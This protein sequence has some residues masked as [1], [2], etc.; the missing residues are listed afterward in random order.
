MSSRFYK[1]LPSD[2][3]C[4]DFQYQEGLNTIALKDC[5]RGFSFADER[6]I[7]YFCDMGSVIA[8]IEIPED[9]TVYLYGAGE[10]KTD[11]VILKNIR[12]LWNMDTINALVQEGVEFE[13]YIND[14]F[15]EAAFNGSLEVVQYLVKQG[16]DIHE[17]DDY[18]LRW[19]SSNGHLDVVKYLIE[20]GANIHARDDYALRLASEEGHFDIVK[21][22]V[23]HGADIH[24]WNDYAFLFAKTPEIEEYLE[25]QN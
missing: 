24:I 1:I 15:R 23:E 4:E 22:L 6:T 18:P 14:M 16:A 13:T 10:Y 17:A 8:E 3:N 25:S 12:Q 9:A 21:Y 20:Q 19:A 2:L 7:L 5:D 11:K